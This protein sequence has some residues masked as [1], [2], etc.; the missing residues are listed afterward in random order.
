M[1]TINSHPDL[2]KIV[3]P[4]NVD[5]FESLLA[6][7]PNRLFVESVCKGLRE[8]FWPWAD[9]HQGEYPS[10][11]DEALDTPESGPEADFLRAQRD[12]KRLTGRFSGSFSQDLLPGMHAS[13]AHAVPKPHSDKLR[14]VIDQ[15]AG[16]FSPNSMIKREHI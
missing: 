6:T 4:I 5:R 12:H 7:H 14:M 13:P 15:S 10:I 1:R 11:V 16:L 8:G 3:T 2:F 9:T